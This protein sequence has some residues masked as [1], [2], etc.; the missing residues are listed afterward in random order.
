[1]AKKSSSRKSLKS[2]F[3]RSEANLD[4]SVQREDAAA[5]AGASSKHEGEK[6][7]FKFPKLRLKPKSS[8]GPERSAGG[9]SEV[10]SVAEP[11]DTAEDAEAWEDKVVLDRKSASLYATAP[12]S[13]SKELS[14]SE[15][16]LR[17]PKRFA[18]FSFGLKKRKRKDEEKLSKSTFVLHSPPI[19]E[20]E[21]TTMD[22]SEMELDQGHVKT[23]FSLSQPEL[24][25]RK[26]FDIPSPPPV[27]TKQSESH[28]P[29]PRPIT[30]DDEDVNISAHHNLPRGGAKSPAPLTDSIPVADTQNA[31]SLS[32]QAASGPAALLSADSNTDATFTEPTLVPDS[33]PGRED[34]SVSH[35]ERSSFPEAA[36]SVSTASAD[37]RAQRPPNQAVVYGELYD[38]LFPQSFSSEV[39]SSL[40]YPP[41]SPLLIHT[42]RIEVNSTLE[43]ALVKTQ[44]VVSS[45]LSSS[46]THRLDDAESRSTSTRVDPRDSQMDANAYRP[47]SLV[48]RDIPSSERTRSVSNVKSDGVGLVQDTV[49]SAPA[50]Q[51]PPPQV[52]DYAA[53]PGAGTQ[54]TASKQ[55]VILVK[56]LVTEEASADSA[57]VSP[58]P[59]KMNALESLEIQI[60]TT[61]FLYAA[62]VQGRGEGSEGPLSPAYLSVGSDDGSVME[63]YY[64][65]EENNQEEEEEESEE[66]EMY[67]MYE[68]EEVDGVKEREWGE[69][70]E[71]G[72]SERGEGEFRVVIVKMQSEEED[73]G[74]DV[75]LLSQTEEELHQPMGHVEETLVP[76]SEMLEDLWSNDTK[77]Q[78]T[79]VAPAELSQ[80]E[81]EE[82][83]EEEEEMHTMHE[84]EEVDGLK[85]RE[86]GEVIETGRSERGEGEFRVVIVKMQSEEGD[87]DLISQTEEELHQPMGHKEEETQVPESEMLECVL[88]NDA[89]RQE[90]EVAPAVLSQIKEEEVEVE[91]EEEEEE[92]REEGKEASLATPVQQVMVCRVAP[93]S[94]EPPHVQGVCSERNW[95]GDL[96]T[97]DH[98]IVENQLPSQETECQVSEDDRSP[99]CEPAAPCHTGEEDV[100][101]PTGREEQ[102]SPGEDKRGEAGT[103]IHSSADSDPSA[104][105]RVLI[106]THSPELQS[107]ATEIGHSSDQQRSEWEDTITG[108][109][110]K[111]RTSADTHRPDPGPAGESSEGH[112][113]PAAA[114][115]DLTPGSPT[116]SRTDAAAPESR[117]TDVD[118]DTLDKMSSGYSSLNTKLTIRSL[119]SLEEDESKQRFHKM[120]LIPEADGRGQDTVDSTESNGTDVGSDYTWRNR[121]EG[122]SQYKPYQVQDSSFSDSQTYTLSDT[123]SSPH[124]SSSSSSISSAYSTLPGATAY[125]PLSDSLSSTASSYSP[126]PEEHSSLS[127]RLRDDTEVDLRRE[128]ERRSLVEQEEPAAPAGEAERRREGEAE[129]I[130]S[131]WDSQQLPVF[132]FSSA[133]HTSHT[134]GISHDDN[135]PSEFTGLF[136]AT[137]VELDCEPAAPPSTPPASPEADSSNQLEMDNLVDTLKNM[138]PSF[139]PRSNGVR[140]PVPTLMSS[141]PPIVEDAPSPISPHLPASLTRPISLLLP[142]SLTSPN[143]LHLPASITSP[144]KT[145]ETNG[146]DKLDGIFSLPPELGLKRN[147]LRDN[148]SPL[149]LL[150]TQQ[151]QQPGTR[152]V[153]RRSS[154]S[155]LEDLKSP[156]LNGNG[157]SPPPSTGSR[158]DNS[159]IYGGYRSSSIDQTMENGKSHRSLFRSGSLPDTGPSGDRLSVGQK[160]LGEP[161]SSRFERFSFLANSSSSSSGSLTGSED[162]NGRM[163]RPPQP[164]FGSPPPSNSPTRLLSPSGSI[165]LHRSFTTTDSPLSMFGQ[166]QGMGIGAGAGTTPPPPLQRSFSSDG[167]GG[168]QQTSLFNSMYGGSRFQSKEPEPDR[169]QAPK[170]RAFPDA[171]LTKAK[172]HGK[173][174]PRPGKMFIF[175]RPGMCGQRIEVR[176]DVTDAT[177]WELQDTISIRVIR[178]GWVMYE[179]PNF[180]GEKYA[181]DEG[182][183]ELSC[184]FSPPE[185][186]QLQNGQRENG[187]KEAVEG[188]GQNGETSDEQTETAPTRKFIIGSLRRA[189][190]DYSVPEIGLFPE[191]NAEGKKVTFRDTSDDARIFGFPIK[192]TSIIINAGLWLVYAEPFFQGVPR[193]LEVGGYSNPAAW[194]VDHPYVGSVHPLKIGEPRVENLSEPKLEIFDKPY[195]CG[196]SRTITTNARDFMTR[197]DRQQTAF[198]YNVGSLKVHGGI[199][200]GYEKEGYRGHQYLLEE[201]EYQDWRVWGGC[202]AELRSIRVIQADL[203]D[204][205]MVMFEQPEEDQEGEEN[206]FEVNEAIPDVELFNFKTSTR[207]IHVV[208]G[209]WVAYSHV[210]FSGNQSPRICSVQPILLAPRDTSK[211]RNQIV[212][213]SEPDFQGKC[214]IFDRNQEAL[215]EKFL[216]KSCRLVSGS[217][218]LYENEK[219]SGNL[220]VLH[221]GDYPNLISM[222]CPPGCN[223][224]SVK[225]VPMMF[226]IPSLSLFGLECLEGREITT[227]SE[228]ISMAGE[229]FNNH[230]LSVRVNSGCWVICEHSNYRGRQ[231][232]LEPIEITNWPKFS[233]L[234]T[235]GSVY[236]VVQK[237]QFFRIK[238]AESGLPMSV[239]G[240]VEEMKSGRVLVTEEVEPMTDIWFYQDGFIKNKLATTMSLQ[241]MGNIEPAAKVVLWSETRQPIQSWTTKM[242]G[243]ITSLT[244]PGMV[245]DVKGGKTY[246]K[247]H[248]VIMP[249][250]DERPSQQWEIELL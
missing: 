218:V 79:E 58:V 45:H 84:R 136:K 43:P 239:Q 99:L 124:S 69:V 138:G 159:L 11:I 140:A 196:K 204:P 33:A 173:L 186:E 247:D 158:L 153:L 21:E 117:Q 200:V 60:D 137:L 38:S 123:Y 87:E 128:S 103:D 17:K 231:F 97:E 24:V 86:W 191:E 30:L 55:R 244:F 198:M 3:S 133:L 170:Y 42:E 52:S 169:N 183:I 57:C 248:V 141:L 227:E 13:K 37:G 224:R 168:V 243:L 190:R 22:L 146:S 208:S 161:A 220:Y 160:E 250:N 100:I 238:N 194:G 144:V 148:R 92:G 61:E 67:T 5:A 154:D 44:S 41:P 95:T 210:D 142:A 187:Q 83:V 68:R 241:V 206:T 130:K 74:D 242:R 51:S 203:S 91:E 172:E 63:V 35:A 101:T 213:F 188:K 47:S 2:W 12:R 143:A 53:S 70:V 126:A 139:R 229:G 195:F 113:H 48:F 110:D 185:E 7:K 94:S 237:R 222:G 20:Q 209:A 216:T 104:G 115:P 225:V 166:T 108:R 109:E 162:L 118:Q 164:N 193:V 65:A 102:V 171:Y 25:P 236:P 192:A 106:P 96:E 82:E 245:L 81:E 240:G 4:E 119:S 66:E 217:W 105:A 120:S 40:S 10:L 93:P 189:V 6:K 75:D 132:G 175:D 214:H 155:F 72:R 163:S 129:R 165:D 112:E 50:V 39:T 73:E 90:T 230:I 134:D 49:R 232:L 77:R 147:F 121:F 54:V 205:L 111:K 64:S 36:K 199:W 27:A 19:D 62:L 181:L 28:F 18:T 234:S 76:E 131:P 246:D 98:L 32:S 15:L 127:Y 201:G 29:S 233:S 1:M 149:E 71:T 46:H 78:E 228:I 152:N 89:K 26:K 249:E 150:K 34:V 107:D 88:S 184:P 177:S 202:D 151:D 85:E 178:G 182:D 80:I 215:S 9:S 207:S 219:H 14:Y 221:E 212:L 16:D 59:D 156:L 211:T 145:M 223:V 157:I 23:M 226:S 122:V 8:A 135:E 174:N 167:P 180:K 114:E 179:K 56:E 176:S 235:I 116:S 197:I 125:K 31:P